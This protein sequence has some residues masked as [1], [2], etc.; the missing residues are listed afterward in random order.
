MS[1]HTRLVFSFMAAGVIGL[2]AISGCEREAVTY[3][4]TPPSGVQ[5][6]TPILGEPARGGGPVEALSNYA[7]IDQLASARCERET[8]CNNVG[9]GKR[10]ASRDACV[11]DLQRDTRDDLSA[12][13][14]PAG[15][16]RAELNECLAEIRNNNCNDPLDT[17]ERVVACRSS[18]MC[19]N[20][21]R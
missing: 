11:A 13:E 3:E 12:G 14:C 8:R 20:I 10:W 2:G 16:D 15:V 4:R 21:A 1:N 6:T 9:A 7:A 19:L 5:G 18:D 17:L